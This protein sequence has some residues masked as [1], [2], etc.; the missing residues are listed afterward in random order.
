MNKWNWLK[1]YMQQNNISQ[2]DVADALQWQKTRVSELLC[3]KRDFPVSKVFPAAQYF[4]LDLEQFT[5]Y[6]S[7]YSKEIPDTAGKKPQ[8]HNNDM[9]S[10]DII[11]SNNNGKGFAIHPIGKQMINNEIYKILTSSKAENVKALIA[12]GDSMQPTI[13][14]GDLVWVDISVTSPTVDGLYLFTIKGELFIKRLSLD[15]FNNSASIISDN[16]LY[17]PIIIDNLNKISPLG[18]IISVTKMYR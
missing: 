3:G 6:N 12:R 17:P 13:N 16:N 1:E 11:D 10:I 15:D 14:D 8:Q 4:N 2:G 5:K 18:K 9:I 7:G